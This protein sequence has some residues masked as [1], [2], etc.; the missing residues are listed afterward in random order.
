[1]NASIAEPIQ[2]DELSSQT[3]LPRLVLGREAEAMTAGW[4]PVDGTV[5]I[6]DITGFTPLSERLAAHGKEGA[7]LLTTI[8]NHYFQRLLDSAVAYGGDNLKF[9]GDALLILFRGEHHADRAVAAA[10]AMQRENR[11]SGAIRVG[12]ERARLQMRISVH[13]DTFWSTVVGKNDVRLQHI[14]AGP[15]IAE[16]AT[17][18]KMAAPGE[19]ALSEA[20]SAVLSDGVVLARRDDTIVARGTARGFVPATPSPPALNG[21][22]GAALNR[23]GLTHGIEGEH[24]K[25]TVM[26]ARLDGVNELLDAGENGRAFEGLNGFV[27]QL[28]RY[29]EQFGGY[30]ASN[31]VDQSGIKFIVL[32]GAPVANEQAA[33]NALRLALALRVASIGFDGG[34]SLRIGLNSGFTF[35]GDVGASHRRE[36]TVLGDAVNLSARLM[37][38]AEAGQILVSD[39][40]AAESGP[41]FRWR[42]LPAMTI[43]GKSQPVPVRLLSGEGRQS[44]STQSQFPFVGRT[45]ER[46]RLA[47][48]IDRAGTGHV[49]VIALTGEPGSGKSRLVSEML[50]PLG[51]RWSVL[52]TEAQS[53]ASGM[54]FAAWSRV[55]SGLLGLRETTDV[56]RR[57]AVAAEAIA[58][59]DPQSLESAALLNPLLS[60]DLPESDLLRSL[61]ADTRRERLLRLFGDLLAASARK[62]PTVVVV[63]DMHWADQSSREV[64]ST[65]AATLA[66]VPLVLWATSREP[67]DIP[68]G[69]TAIA[70]SE[71]TLDDAE[72][73]LAS[74][75]GAARLSPEVTAAIA[76]KCRGNPLF[77]EEVARAFVLENG[78][79]AGDTPVV[80]DRLQSLL[81]ARLDSLPRQAR[82]VARV[83]SVL[84]SA[85]DSEIV[86]EM[87]PADTRDA[88][89]LSLRDLVASSVI[90]QDGDGPTYYRFRHSLQQEVAY[91]SLLFARRR[92]LHRSVTTI[93][94]HRNADDLNPV[95][96]TLAY[97]TNLSGDA[98]KNAR[99]ATLAG[100]KARGVYAWE[101]A[102]AYYE[103]ALQALARGP[104]RHAGVRSALLERIGD[105]LELAGR[106]A[107]AAEIYSRALNAW[108]IHLRTARPGEIVDI[109]P[110]GFDTAARGSRLR[111]KIAIAWERSSQYDRSLRWLRAARS[112]MPSRRAD[113]RADIYSSWS[114]VLF[115]KGRFTDAIDLARK[116]LAAARTTGKPAQIAYSHHVLANC[117]GETGRLRRSVFHREAALAI[118]EQLGDVPRLFAGH[119]N[120]G[121]SY[122][123]LGDFQLAVHHHQEC[124]KAAEQI[125]NDV[126]AAIGQNNL[127]EVLLAQG[128]V[129]EAGACF[130]RTI[131]VFRQR[132][133]PRVPAGL[134]LVNLSRVDLQ[135]GDALAAKSHL[136]EGMDLLG[137]VS[138]GLAT[139]G[140]LQE[141]EIALHLGELD[142]AESAATRA[143]DEADALGMALLEA[144]ALLL[145]S[146]IALAQDHLGE[147]TTRAQRSLSIARR[148]GAAY[149][150]AQAYVALAE[151]AA[152]PGSR[153]S[154]GRA[155]NFAGAAAEL[156]ERIG[157]IGDLDRVRQLM[158]AA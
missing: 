49:Q 52:R 119:G 79:A 104:D 155:R 112:V 15:G 69:H 123:G 10:L 16:L 30:V 78:G 145:H 108:S 149:E 44:S 85:F 56:A 116:A 43:K 98:Q 37:S 137:A 75:F 28:V 95:V 139:E 136:S 26:F 109:L 82:R 35:C 153:Q 6:A 88:L 106:Y 84:G 63:E 22:A 130:T 102:I 18:D 36:Y 72:A 115:R 74:V 66:D 151:I 92:E 23:W 90:Y 133:E 142:A 40:T 60:V 4:V 80:P 105:C 132:G 33:A 5:V 146:R 147:A 124:I 27:A 110:A 89:D 76:E 83:A 156:L 118:Y 20:T 120:L 154:R 9:G 50:Q 55:L 113:L 47:E 7:E 94:E 143:M 11:R 61:D 140:I 39:A 64:L 38:R 141:A 131:D 100:D 126:A 144:R 1:M 17:V 42:P 59:L 48:A 34:L 12:T 70:L 114:V 67:M 24:R 134:A 148:L 121:L 107:Q 25:V 13:S 51:S 73:L 65:L 58:Q 77:L 157:A 99:Y 158:S 19:V 87:L 32:F 2:H 46:A 125:G 62:K 127:G 41:T 96:E 81:M 138:R 54:P 117:Y 57:T 53:F 129:A 68:V 31:D 128:H 135:N 8:I 122:Q 97:H 93:L 71:L 101:S 21:D 3:Y 152:L 45:A 14:I 91:E 103:T 86:R 29:A 150:T 111:L